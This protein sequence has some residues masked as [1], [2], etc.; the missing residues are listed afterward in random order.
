MIQAIQITKIDKDN[1]LNSIWLLDT[2]N[3]KARCLAALKSQSLVE[4][5]QHL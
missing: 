2:E 4:G 3:N 5:G 1:L